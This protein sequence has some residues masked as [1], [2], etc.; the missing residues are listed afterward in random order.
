MIEPESSGIAPFRS[1]RL[2]RAI[3]VFAYRPD[4]TGVQQRARQ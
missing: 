3:V 2:H 4:I 1:P